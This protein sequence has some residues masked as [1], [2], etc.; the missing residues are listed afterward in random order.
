MLAFP[1]KA[2]MTLFLGDRASGVKRMKEGK[3]QMF[4][5]GFAVVDRTIVSI[6]SIPSGKSGPLGPSGFSPKVG[7]CWVSRSATSMQSCYLQVE[8]QGSLRCTRTMAGPFKDTG[9]RF[10]HGMHCLKISHYRSRVRAYGECW[11]RGRRGAQQ[12]RDGSDCTP[13]RVPSNADVQEVAA[14]CQS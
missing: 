5:H 6:K 13:R 14:V 1:S 8:R 3:K 10:G 9:R 12:C 4:G 11:R 2:D 7:S